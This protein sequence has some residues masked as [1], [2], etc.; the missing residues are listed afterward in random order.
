[1]T[2]EGTNCPLCSEPLSRPAERIGTDCWGYE[3]PNCGVFSA[4]GSLAETG[5]FKRLTE[6]ERALLSHA[7]Y[8]MRGDG[9]PPQLHSHNLRNLIENNS[10]PSVAEQRNNLIVWFGK[11]APRPGDQADCNPYNLRAAL[12]SLRPSEAA[13]ALESAMQEGLLQGVPVLREGDIMGLSKAKLKI[14]GWKLL[15]EIQRGIN[16]SRIAFMAMQYGDETLNKIVREI[17][18]PAVAQT[19]FELRRLDDLPKAGLID[20]RLRVEI[21]TSKFIIA[22]LTHENRGAYWEAGFAEGLGKPVIYTCESKKFGEQKSHFD[23]NHH[24][25][26]TWDFDK[27]DA[28]AEDLKA[29]IRATLPAEAK[30]TDE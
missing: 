11:N 25:T 18:A 21:L 10:L 24:Q 8:R 29:T 19:G 4:V 15:E 22:D 14:Q 1:M 30:L 23:T 9:K 3:C 6:T 27:S 12:G 2:S 5:A 7:I 16:S 28:T 26:V 17:F 20:D 13:F